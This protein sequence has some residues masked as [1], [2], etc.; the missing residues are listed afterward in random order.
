MHRSLGVEFSFIQSLKLDVWPPDQLATFLANGNDN[1]II[2]ARLEH[3]VPIEI[4]KPN[5]HSSTS[6]REKFIIEKYKHR[7]FSSESGLSEKS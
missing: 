7:S 4:L 1:I 2:N 3:C 5:P 6:L